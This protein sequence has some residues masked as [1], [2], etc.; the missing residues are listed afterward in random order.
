MQLNW[1]LEEFYADGGMTKFTE[2][3]ATALNVPAWR[4]KT[5][6]VYEG[7]VIVDFFLLP[8]PDARDPPGELQDMSTKLAQTLLKN[9]N[10]DVLGAALIGAESN[11]K[12]LFGP[13]SSLLPPNLNVIKEEE[14]GA[15]TSNMGTS[16]MVIPSE[17]SQNMYMS[18]HIEFEEESPT[19]KFGSI[20]NDSS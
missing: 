5:V 10:L 6:A 2:R 12:K 20:E 7:S 15:G 17:Y 3:V 8:D 4:I 11:G 13:S 1:T 18:K 16:G 19:K 14:V 9:Q